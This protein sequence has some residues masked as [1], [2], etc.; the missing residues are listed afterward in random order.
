MLS[1]KTQ[2]I[3]K[4]GQ[5]DKNGSVK[6]KHGGRARTMKS[7]GLAT[8]EKE[9]ARKGVKDSVHMQEKVDH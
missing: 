7:T 9:K 4:I 5:E 6:R 3:Q 2:D 1:K 8:K